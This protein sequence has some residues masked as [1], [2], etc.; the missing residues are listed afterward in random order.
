MDGPKVGLDLSRDRMSFLRSFQPQ[1]VHQLVKSRPTHPQFR[2]SRTDL[3]P[4][5]T[6]R[7]LDNVALDR[8]AGFFERAHGGESYFGSQLE[9]VSRDLVAFRHDDTPFNPVFQFADVA[10]PA[11][12]FNGQASVFAETQF[13]SGILRGE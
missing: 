9:I 7:L 6:E 2:R 12:T 4:V 3:A 5:S 13:A 8:F 1:L 11:I 10:R